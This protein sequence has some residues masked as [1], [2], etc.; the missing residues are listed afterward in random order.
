MSALRGWLTQNLMTKALALV[1]AVL[2]W[3]FVDQEVSGKLSRPRAK[4][5][6][7]FEQK[8][9]SVVQITDAGGAPVDWVNV[10]I[11]GPR[12]SLGDVPREVV[13]HHIIQEAL[14]RDARPTQPIRVVLDALDLKLPSRVLATITPDEVWVTLDQLE[15]G[16]VRIDTSNCVGG[17]PRAGYNVSVQSV[18]PSQIRVRAPAALIE[19]YKRE[20]LPILPIPVGDL[21]ETTPFAASFPEAIRQ[22]VQIPPGTVTVTIRVEPVPEDYAVTLPVG[23]LLPA[24]T[25]YE[26][27]LKNPREV[28]VTLRGPHSLIE[29][30]KL[31][32]MPPVEVFVDLAD[33]SVS[34]AQVNGTISDAPLTARIRNPEQFGAL[35]IVGLP[36]KAEAVSVTEKK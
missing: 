27:A 5:E 21:T 35:A 22:R 31:L 34:P 28:K 4:V 26:F 10:E 32:A 25:K 12:G 14:T 2:V 8:D 6:L 23:L 33:Y 15:G 3:Y 24:E 29:R 13:C 9:V 7:E 17:S 18:T 30:A 20:G 19:R 16:Y 36:D 11:R 1:L